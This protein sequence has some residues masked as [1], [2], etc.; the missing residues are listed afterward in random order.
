ML[1]RGRSITQGIKYFIDIFETD[2]CDAVEIASYAF[3]AYF[4][5]ESIT[6]HLMG[7]TDFTGNL[8]TSDL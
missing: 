7:T 2:L 4:G 5:K 1:M 8:Y 3:I 6:F